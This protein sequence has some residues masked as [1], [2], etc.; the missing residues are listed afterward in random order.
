MARHWFRNP[1]AAILGSL[2]LISLLSVA[3]GSAEEPT[4][5]P[6]ATTAAPEAAPDEA[7]EATTAAPD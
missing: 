2:L 6:A 4:A 1:I 3:C 5:V 7:M